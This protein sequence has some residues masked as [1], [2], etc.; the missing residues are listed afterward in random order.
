MDFGDR[1]GLGCSGRGR[2]LGVCGYFSRTPA[3]ARRDLLR[4]GRPPSVP[5]VC[6]ED[7]GRHTYLLARILQMETRPPHPDCDSRRGCCPVPS[8]LSRHH[9][10][11]GHPAQI[12]VCWVGAWEVVSGHVEWFH[13][14]MGEGG[15]SRLARPGSSSFPSPCVSVGRDLGPPLERAL[16]TEDCVVALSIS[17]RDNARTRQRQTS[18]RRAGGAVSPPLGTRGAVVVV[19]AHIHTHTHVNTKL[20][21]GRRSR[22]RGRE[23]AEADEWREREPTGSAVRSARCGAHWQCHWHW[24]CSGQRS[25]APNACFLACSSLGAT[26]R[27]CGETETLPPEFHRLGMPVLWET[28][29]KKAG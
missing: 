21:V 23:P 28:K 19:H 20:M 13:R 17:T 16:N 25:C 24:Q 18:R 1:S 27:G 12:W 11:L 4:A 15:L 2:A 22:G 3:A 9:R 5:G 10:L 6:G 14:A 26:L 8:R 7:Y 29:K